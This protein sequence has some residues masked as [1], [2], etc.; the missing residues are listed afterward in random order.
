MEKKKKSMGT[1]QV[2][3]ESSEN[4]YGLRSYTDGREMW[5]IMTSK[6]SD[7]EENEAK[8]LNDSRFE[9]TIAIRIFEK[10]LEYEDG[11]ISEEFLHKCLNLGRSSD[12]LVGFNFFLHSEKANKWYS[13]IVFYNN[14]ALEAHECTEEHFKICDEL[15]ELYNIGAITL[16]AMAFFKQNRDIV[17]EGGEKFRKA[18]LE[19]WDDDEKY[20]KMLKDILSP[21][22]AI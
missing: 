12:Y 16:K 10:M 17:K 3:T 6:W 13:S 2:S 22:L 20:T 15:F 8:I 11:E 14:H 9:K 1:N 5:K 21:R 19:F 7:E 4:I 18:F